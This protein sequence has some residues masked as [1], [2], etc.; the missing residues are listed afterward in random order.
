MI[1]RSIE[2]NGADVAVIG[3]G[4]YGLAV[5][6]HLRGRGVATHTFGEPMSFW[7][8]HMPRGMKLRSPLAATD[9]SDPDEALS[10]RAFRR[11]AG[12]DLVE[13][14]PIETFIAYGEWFQTR[15]VPDLDRRIVARVEAA[16][17][18]FLV[19]P[20]E[21]EPLF[22]R[23]VVVATG[24]EG[25]RF[26]P[27]AFAFAP[28]ASVSHTCDHADF[29]AFRDKRV[30][31]IGRGQSACETAA[32]LSEAG[33]RAEIICRG[34]I[35]WLGAGGRGRPIRRKLSALARAPSAVGPFP[36]DWLV[37][38][39]GLVRRLPAD[40]R[41]AF[42]AASLR[43]GAAGWL[44]PRFADVRVT[45]GVEVV[46]AAAE[47]EGIRVKFDRGGSAVFDRVVLATGYRFDVAGL[48]MLAPG[49]RSAIACRAGSPVLSA[50]FESSAPGLHFV[51]AGA[52]SSL[53]PLMRFI[54]GVSFTARSVARAIATSREAWRP[55]RQN[56]VEYDL[57]A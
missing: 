11:S 22:A 46:D 47:G 14:L 5:S 40:A 48:G 15:A 13:P 52:V 30:A 23:R 35:R 41:A 19:S 50:G 3:A 8:R 29:D 54:A 25:H 32:L 24:L 36:L 34:P 27:P 7:R 49:L 26:R 28:T 10:L 43:A 45:S 4:P 12:A 39:P 2:R 57:T 18:G 21:G 9:I 42:N 16:A 51:G 44:Q 20:T 55:I 38:L 53:G 6:A 56:R 33:A 17:N 31:V 1:A 37:E